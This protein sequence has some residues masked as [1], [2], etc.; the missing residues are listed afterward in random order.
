MKGQ[1][2]VCVNSTGE[3]RE[4]GPLG[5]PSALRKTQLTVMVVRRVLNAAGCRRLGDSF[6]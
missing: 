4:E 3:L 5:L 2:E 1:K 6:Q